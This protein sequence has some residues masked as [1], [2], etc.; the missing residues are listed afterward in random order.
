MISESKNIKKKP[1][2]ITK[3][4][5]RPDKLYKGLI[6]DFDLYVRAAKMI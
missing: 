3:T 1:S 5:K 6:F 2:I 4:S